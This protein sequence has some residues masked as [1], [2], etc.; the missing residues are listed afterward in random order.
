[1]KTQKNKKV[2]MHEITLGN[3]PR[4]RDWRVTE[5]R[6]Q[7]LKE[8]DVVANIVDLDL[9]DDHPQEGSG[10]FRITSPKGCEWQ[11]VTYY[12]NYGWVTRDEL[13]NLRQKEP[14]TAP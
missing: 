2:G 5:E 3:P 9:V 14:R 1:M 6:R 12:S 11:S 8:G 13:A 10:A 7:K 4:P